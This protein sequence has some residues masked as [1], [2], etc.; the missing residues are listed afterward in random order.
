MRKENGEGTGIMHQQHEAQEDE[1]EH[2]SAVA[3]L[4]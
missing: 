1:E 4:K 3:E 2:D